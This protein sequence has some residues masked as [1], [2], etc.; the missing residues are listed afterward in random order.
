M[1]PEQRHHQIAEY[2]RGTL[3][4]QDRQA[5]E[6]YLK[7]DESARK[8]MEE[9]RL[10]NELMEVSIARDTR[11]LLS[12]TNVST[13]PI[14]S[15]NRMIRYAAVAAGILLIGVIGAWLYSSQTYAPQQLA[16]TYVQHMTLPGG[17][18]RGDGSPE[19]HPAYAE[20]LDALA[21]S[22]LEGAM[23]QFSNVPRTDPNYLES[24]YGLGIAQFKSRDYL[25]AAST[26][27]QCI[28]PGF[29]LAQDASWNRI[30]CMLM[31]PSSDEDI[32]IGLRPL[33]ENPNHAYH[34][35]AIELENK[36]NSFWYQLAN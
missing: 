28:Q 15:I 30:L 14:H 8:D 11:N 10:V 36:L 3:P 26:F 23:I 7:T 13:T 17:S 9:Q 2:L 35:K 33:L 19:L 24:L 6:A 21:A 25:T 16:S 4:D 20:A 29:A 5:L 12:K 1:N 32:R 18:V 34:Q 27:K 31:S 22:D